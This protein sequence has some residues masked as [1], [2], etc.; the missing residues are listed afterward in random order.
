MVADFVARI[1]VEVIPVLFVKLLELAAKPLYNFMAR[2]VSVAQAY[3]YL[4]AYANLEEIL[5]DFLEKYR[6][7]VKQKPLPRRWGFFVM[8]V[9]DTCGLC[10]GLVKLAIQQLLR[11]GDIRA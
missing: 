4:E 1:I 11:S 10:L 3:E 9:M 8:L 7:L 5:G 2:L 6:C